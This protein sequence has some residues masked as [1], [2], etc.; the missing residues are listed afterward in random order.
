MAYDPADGSV[1]LFGGYNPALF[2]NLKDTWKFAAGKWTQLNIVGPSARANAMMA[3]DPKDRCVVLHGGYSTLS[4]VAYNDTWKFA[5]GSWTKVTP[6]L[7]PPARFG[8]MMAYDPAIGHVVLFGGESTVKWLNDTWKFVNGTW[9]H[10]SLSARPSARMLSGFAYF[11]RDRGLILFGGTNSSA[12]TSNLTDT[13]RFSNGTW[14]KLAA[15]PAPPARADMGMVLDVP[16]GTILMFG[17][18]VGNRFL[19]DTWSFG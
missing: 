4:A 8:G 1:L 2:S 14:S 9:S 18:Q 15:T 5:H 12:F 3:Y 6:T 13:W 7:S 11:P 10:V 17:G 19:G 16:T